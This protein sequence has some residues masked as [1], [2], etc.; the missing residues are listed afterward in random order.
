MS[1]LT[2]TDLQ[3]QIANWMHRTDLGTYIPDFITLAELKISHSIRSRNLQVEVQTPT[4]QGVNTITLPIDYASLKTIQILNTT[5]HNQVLTLLPDEKFLEY[6]TYNTQGIPKFYTIQAGNILLQ[7][8]PDGVYTID[9]VY[10]QDVP[11]L[12]I[13]GTNWVMTKFPRV[14]LY[15]ALIEG[16][17]FIQDEERTQLYQQRFDAAIEEMWRYFTNESFS[18]SPLKAV[19]RYIM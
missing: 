19:S 11:S 7:P 10:Y 17:T 9:Y 5:G 16:C 18:G 12:A 4:V 14:Y 2:Y 6:N 1:L 13:N 15:G 3:T 8:I